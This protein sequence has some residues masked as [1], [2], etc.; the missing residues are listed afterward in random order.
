MSDTLAETIGRKYRDAQVAIDGEQYEE[1]RSA[2]E[3]LLPLLE[4]TGD[5]SGQIR[6]LDELGQV[7]E[8][9]G[10]LPSARFSFESALQRAPAD[11]GPTRLRLLHRLAHAWRPSDPAR[12]QALFR[13]CADLADSLGD[14][15]AAALSRAMIGQI[16]ITSGD[17]AGGMTRLL[18]A[19]VE[20][21]PDAPERSHL[22]EHAA[23]LSEQLPRGLFLRLLESHVPPGPLALAL[24]A[25]VAN[26]QSRR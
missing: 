9:L 14:P 25:A 6:V 22:I 11:C 13:Q 18:A 12:A 3:S 15:R 2:L 23:Y 16:E 17:P 10:D 24:V 4:Q 7:H 8:L 26:R 19:L 5:R 1:A 20:L 21:P